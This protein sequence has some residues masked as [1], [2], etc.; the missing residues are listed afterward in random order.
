M[1][2]KITQQRKTDFAWASI[3]GAGAEPV[4]LIDVDGRKGILT[5]G[6]QDPFWLDDESAGIVVFTGSRLE[7]PENPETQEQRDKRQDKYKRKEAAV[8]AAYKWHRTHAK[9]G[10]DC[11]EAGCTGKENEGTH[12]WRGPR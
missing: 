11:D 7:R 5:I 1:P 8:K 4:E 9:H 6:C 3:A 10:P 2:D 12:G